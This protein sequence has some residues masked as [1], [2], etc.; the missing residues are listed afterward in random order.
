MTDKPQHTPG[1]WLVENKTVYA[2]NV[3][4]TNRFSALIQGG[5]INQSRDGGFE[6]T[7]EGELLANARHIVHCVNNHDALI[8]AL[9]DAKAQ[10][11]Y[12]QSKF[13]KTGTGEATIS[14]ISAALS[15]A[16]GE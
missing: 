7:S 13:Q 11:T 10:I 2:L 4:D 5:F 16:K 6:R 15:A 8:E 9:L 3:S 12:L 14:R 1:P